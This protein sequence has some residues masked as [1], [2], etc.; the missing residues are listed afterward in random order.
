MRYWDTSDRVT[1]HNLRY[2]EGLATPWGITN[3][4]QL[5]Q[6]LIAGIR[7][8]EMLP[9]AVRAH[10]DWPFLFLG[11]SHFSWK[12]DRLQDEDRKISGKFGE[13][14]ERVAADPT[15]RRDGGADFSDRPKSKGEVV[16][17]A[18][19]AYQDHQNATTLAALYSALYG[20]P[21][22]HLYQD[23]ERALARKRAPANQTLEGMIY[24]VIYDIRSRATEFHHEK[25]G[26]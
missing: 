1:D 9:K 4:E 18:L 19:D 8:E 12:T 26:L 23:L 15:L 22:I 20:T 6:K 2:V 17:A 25:A 16:A 21:F 5:H 3:P 11:N 14:L 13:G 24:N 10:F 7:V